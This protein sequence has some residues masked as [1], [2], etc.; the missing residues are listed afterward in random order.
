MSSRSVRRTCKAVCIFQTFWQ[1][2]DHTPTWPGSQGICTNVIFIATAIIL[3]DNPCQVN[4]ELEFYIC[5]GSTCQYESLANQRHFYTLQDRCADLSPSLHF[6]GCG[7]AGRVIIK[8]GFFVV[9][10]IYFLSI[11]KRTDELL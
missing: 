3:L 8:P 9:A 1:G 4:L 11:L 7:Q 2:R 10:T 6:S 5:A